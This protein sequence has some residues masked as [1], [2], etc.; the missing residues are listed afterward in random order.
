MQRCIWTTLNT[1]RRKMKVGYNSN[2]KNE[3]IKKNFRVV[4]ID[5]EE[6]VCTFTY[7]KNNVEPKQP[8]VTL[9]L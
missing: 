8:D 3:L 4:T 2:L 1:I 5:K 9:L 6:R 7:D